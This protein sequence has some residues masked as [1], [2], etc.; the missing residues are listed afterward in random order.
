MQEFRKLD[1]AEMNR[2]SAEQYCGSPKHPIVLMLHNIR[3]MWTVSY[4]H[5]TLPTKA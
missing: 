3:S 5:L 1:G 4:T 2:M